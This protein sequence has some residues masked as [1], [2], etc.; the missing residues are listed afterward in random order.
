MTDAKLTLWDGRE[1][2]RL[3]MGGWPIAGPFYAGELQL[4]YASIE[5]RHAVNLLRRAAD[6]GIR[7]F[8]TAAVYGAGASESLF[9]E[10]F[11][12]RHDVVVAT[13]FG[14]LFDEATKQVT[15]QDL[16]PDFPRRDVERSL[17]RLRRE[18]IDLYQLHVNSAPFRRRNSSLTR[19]TSSSV[20]ER[21]APMAGA[22][23]FPPTP[24]QSA[25]AR[26]LSRCST[27]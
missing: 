15:G 4:G 25:R 11:G 7:F 8:D 3:G 21:S 26:T 18:R 6:A 19:W 20:K 5:A 16:T 24:R 1:I 9:G 2:P 12:N 10:A 23:T 17:K 27:R 14:P 22:R 13:K